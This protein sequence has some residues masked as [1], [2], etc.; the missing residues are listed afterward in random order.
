MAVTS[1]GD[2][3]VLI[4]RHGPGDELTLTVSRD[5]EQQ[6]IT[7]TLGSTAD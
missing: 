1:F 5:G 6:E 7:A 3:G 2:L 4:R